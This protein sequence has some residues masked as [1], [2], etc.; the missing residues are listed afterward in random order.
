MLFVIATKGKNGQARV[1]GG[2]VEPVEAFK[3]GAGGV[4]I[5][6]VSRGGLG[7]LAL[8]TCSREPITLDTIYAPTS[9]GAIVE[10][11]GTDW[12]AEARLEEIPIGTA[13]ANGL[14]IELDTVGL[15]CHR[16]ALSIVQHITGVAAETS[17][18]H[19]C[20]GLALQIDTQALA[21]EFVVGRF[22]TGAVVVDAVNKTVG[23]RVF[24]SPQ[25][26]YFEQAK[27]SLT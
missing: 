2:K 19:F 18:T 25:A 27:P 16:Y 13:L 26:P 22:A 1:L 14:E 9:S 8:P 7:F 12:L 10:T 5:Q 11:E 24:L 21:P 4:S 15:G 3:A 20:V 23:V 6:A 17:P